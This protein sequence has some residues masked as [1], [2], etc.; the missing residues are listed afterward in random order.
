[1]F[2][3]PVLLANFSLGEKQSDGGIGFSPSNSCLMSS[4]PTSPNSCKA[5]SD[6]TNQILLNSGQDFK[7][8]STCFMLA[9]FISALKKTSPCRLS[10]ACIWA[11][12]I[13]MAPAKIIPITN[14]TRDIPTVVE[15]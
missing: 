14:K 8:N 15:T 6:E 10:F 2:F 9:S 12:F 5:L 13:P 1:M 7:D 3:M 4:F 11:V